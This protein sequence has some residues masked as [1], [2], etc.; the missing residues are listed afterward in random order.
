MQTFLP[1]PEFGVSASQLDRARLGKQRLEC[2]QILN[3]LDKMKSG[4]KVGW[5]NH[6]AV[7][8][9]KGHEAALCRYSIAICQEWRCRGYKDAMLD[10]FKG[11][12]LQY[13]E[14]DPNTDKN[15]WW[16]GHP[17]LHA[18]HRARLLEKDLGYYSQFGW[19]ETPVGPEGYFWPSKNEHLRP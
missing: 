7:L 4:V 17:Q 13:L 14:N 16:I 18:S 9:W 5:G 6:P 12:Y 10:E 11:R 8:M 19:V 1:S 2:K 3:A 15:P